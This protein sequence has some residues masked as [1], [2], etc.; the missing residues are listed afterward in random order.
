[1]PDE[2]MNEQWDTQETAPEQQNEPPAEPQAAASQEEDIVGSRRGEVKPVRKMS[3]ADFKVKAEPKPEPVPEVQD[4]VESRQPESAEQTPPVQSATPP[5]QEIKSSAEP[6]Q[7]PAQPPVQERPQSPVQ[8]ATPPVQERPV[9]EARTQPPVQ[10]PVQSATPPA[11]PPARPPAQER[12]VQEARTQPPVQPPVQSA[13][14]PVQ[15]PVQEFKPVQGRQPSP[16]VEAKAPSQAPTAPPIQEVPPEE[17]FPEPPA[18]E[19][20]EYT[21]YE[22]PVREPRRGLKRTVKEPVKYEDDDI[23]P[24]KE[25][26]VGALKGALSF[27]TLFKLNVGKNEMD[28]L[29]K[30][31]YISPVAGFIIGMVAALVGVLLFELN[32]GIAIAAVIVA[33]IF[34]LSKFLHFDGL[35][36]F[37]DGIIVSGDKEDHIRALKDTNIG[38]GGM[39][40]ALV[41]TLVT[42]AGL[43]ELSLALTVFLLSMVVITAEVFAK[44]AM[45][46][47]AA[48]GKPGEGMAAKQVHNSD[49]ITM[50]MSTA[51][52]AVLAILGYLMMG[53]I[54]TV[55]EVSMFYGDAYV[56]IV[57]TI[58][59]SAVISIL[60]GWLIA[61]T[62]NRTFGYVNGDVLGA[63]NEIARALVVIV[64]AIVISSCVLWL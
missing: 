7:P 44:N 38:A 21:P 17:D 6:P 31:F 45:V 27:F 12:P 52:S 28:A 13:T 61:N 58:A 47:A 2:E 49:M 11:Q 10:P 42:F 19:D 23:T 40:V 9:Q 30:N 3:A 25:G 29:N 4:V 57:L 15:P 56:M 54:V 33:M 53:A 50:F 39:G 35:A 14:P 41:V 63:T 8:P 26:V 43:A 34:M 16:Q 32:L 48:F 60:A 59:A 1:M 46:A 22:A 37:G 64:A 62:A 20:Y 24:T 55:L 18:E 5:A 51:I 36:D